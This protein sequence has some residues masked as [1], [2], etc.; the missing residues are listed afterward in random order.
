M[1]ILHAAT[2][3]FAVAVAVMTIA[4]WRQTK[5]RNAG[6][7]DV[8]WASLVGGAAVF[9]AV[10]GH[11][12][13]APRIALAA[14]AGLW[15]LRLASHLYRRVSH[16][17]ED[18]RYAYLREHWNDDQ[19]KFFGMFM[20]QALL[21]MFFSVPFAVVAS[22]PQTH[23]FNIGLAVAI[24]LVSLGGES[25]ADR[26]L[27]AWRT[28][29]A[30]RGRTC[31]SGLWRYS[32]HPNYFFE[33]THWFAYVA[34][35]IGAPNWWLSLFGPAAMLFSLVWLTG[36]PFVEAQS[37][38]SRGDDYRRY[39]RETSVFIPWFPKKGAPDPIH[40]LT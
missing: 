31:R 9:Y 28:D 38:R 27:A 15:A 24:W 17:P 22:N 23:A 26:Q 40:P 30:N 33:W 34:L 14:L 35:A 20:A 2:I 5:T 32:R 29:P 7:V 11:G 37:L 18:G 4:W 25:I 36:I 21:V 10:V 16:E 19:R 13:T 1:T 3:L 8:V 6:F 12:A 39:Q